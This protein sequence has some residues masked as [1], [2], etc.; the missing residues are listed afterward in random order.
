M[1]QIVET[2]YTVALVCVSVGI[3]AFGA[4][5]VARLFKGQA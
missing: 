1:T 2:G 3:V 5:V 4:M